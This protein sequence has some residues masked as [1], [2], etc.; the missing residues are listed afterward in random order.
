M[1]AAE[2]GLQAMDRKYIYFFSLVLFHYFF[3]L[4]VIKFSALDD[5]VLDGITFDTGWKLLLIFSVRYLWKVPN[6]PWSA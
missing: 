1:N 4:H 3:P 5:Y 6:F 2:L